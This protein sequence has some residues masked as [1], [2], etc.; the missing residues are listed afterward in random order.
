MM[1]YTLARNA[2][3]IF[4]EVWAHLFAGCMWGLMV[5]GLV[6]FRV[7]GPGKKVWGLN[8]KPKLEDSRHPGSSYTRFC[9]H[10]LG[11]IHKQPKASAY[12]YT[13]TNILQSP[14]WRSCHYFGAQACTPRLLGPL[15]KS[16]LCSND[17][18]STGQNLGR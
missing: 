4:S 8:P 18:V 16:Q 12:R 10:S 13:S 2:E 3:T 9:A 5:S 11:H 7:Q 17:N 14:K 1:V 15:G 6:Q